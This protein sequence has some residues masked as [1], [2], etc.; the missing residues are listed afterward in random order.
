MTI[1]FPNFD[2]PFLEETT[3]VPDP[4]NKELFLPWLT[5]LYEDI[6]VVVNDKDWRTFTIPIGA[7][8]SDIPNIANQ[9]AF[10]ICICGE[11]DGMPGCT[12]SLIKTNSTALGVPSMLQS[13]SGT[14]IGDDFSWLGVR[15]VIPAVTTLTNFQIHHDGASDL[16]G[17]FIIRFIGTR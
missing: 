10:I 8:V 5:R 17:N 1:T 12:Y 11:N 2:F 3:I 14:Q 13:E 4:S 16:I 15:L 7:T 9:G 6:A